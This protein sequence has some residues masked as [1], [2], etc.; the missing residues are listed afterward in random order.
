M[1]YVQKINTILKQS[2]MSE[3]IALLL[4]ADVL[5]A[6]QAEGRHVG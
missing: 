5:L 2:S 6:F 1:C 4:D 3:D